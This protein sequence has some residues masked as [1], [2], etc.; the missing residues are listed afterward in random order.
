MEL[1]AQGGIGTGSMTCAGISSLVIAADKVQ[2]SDARAVDDQIECCLEHDT[3]DSN[4]IERGIQWLARH[5]SVV[6]NPG[7][8]NPIWRLYYLYGLERAGR[9]TVR[10]LID[11]HDW[12]REG[13][14]QLIRDQDIVSG[15]WNGSGPYEGTPTIG[16]SLALLFLSKGRWPVL[17]GKLQHGPGDDWNR[18]RSDVGNLTRYVESRW[19]RDLTWQIIDLRLATVDELLQTPVLYLC[20]DQSPLPDDPAD[21]KQLA[22]K[23]RDYLDRGGFLLAEG[24][25][26]GTGFDGGFRELMRLVF[27]EPEYKL[28]LLD[29]EHPIWYAEEKVNPKQLRPLWGVEFGCRTSVVYAPVNP[30]PPLSCLWELGRP[31]RGEKYGPAVQAQIN[32]AMSLG[33]NVLAYATNRELKSKESYFA[34]STTPRPTDRTVRGRLYVATLRHPG[35]CNTAPRAVINLMDAAS[36]EMKI[37][38]QVREEPLDITDESLFDYHLVFMHGRTAFRLTD[39]ERE[40]LRQYIE[41]GGVLFADSICASQAFT[42]SFRREIATIFP[43]RKLERIPVNDRLLSTT[44]GGFDL[45]TVSRRDPVGDRSKGEPLD[46]AIRKVPPDLE[47]IKLEDRWGVIFSPY[48]VSCALEKHNSPECRGYT[49]DDAARIGLNVVFYSLQ[50]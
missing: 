7:I 29:P 46:D 18:H 31:G 40:R 16:T 19:K 38:P 45:R 34:A 41:R 9:L 39:G 5:Y 22:G 2:A 3:K 48:D 26:G 10:R 32:A 25:C 21:R 13:A 17:L 23:V 27:P 49:R 33:V 37:R 12:Y 11:K 24:Y 42:A 35:G 6:Y 50:Q 4:R 43:N 28:Q 30:Q 20:G 15:S 44:Y 8:S 36:R 47:G 1:P 14:D